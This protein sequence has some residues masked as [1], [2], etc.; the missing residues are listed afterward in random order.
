MID[1]DTSSCADSEL[2]EARP[3]SSG[4]EELQLQIALA[5]SKE[6]AEKVRALFLFVRF[7]FINQLL[8]LSRT[9]RRRR[10]TTFG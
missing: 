6:E 3:T 2:E 5:L 4:E 8:P 1:A 10:G 9:L 7:P